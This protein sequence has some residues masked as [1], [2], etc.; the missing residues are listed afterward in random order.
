MAGFFDR[1]YVVIAVAALAAC[2]ASQAQSAEKPTIVVHA[3][4]GAVQ[5]NMVD[6]LQVFK[7]IPYAL[8]PVGPLRWRAPLPMPPWQ[9]VREATSFGP[10]CHQPASDSPSIYAW[11]AQSMSEDCLSLN[12]WAPVKA[13]HAPVFVWI[14]G[15]ALLT[16]SGADPMYDGTTLSRAGLIVV[17]INY[18]LGALGYLAHPALSAESSQKVSGNYGLL[19]QIAA[20]RWVKANI[21]AFGGDPDNV[22]V[23]GESAGGLS[24]MYLLASPEARGLFAKAISESAYMISTPELREPRFGSE[25]AETI[26]V[27]LANKLGTQDL[28]QLRG[29]DAARV[30]QTG[31]QAGGLPSAVVDGRILPRQLVDVFDRGE[32]AKVPLLVGFNSGE[33]RSLRMLAP[34]LPANADSYE[35]TIR[36]R[37]ADLS[38]DFLR[39]YPSTNLEGSLLATT[40]DA[41]YGWTAERL[42]IKQTALGV[43]AFLYYFDHGYPAADAAGLH[44]F[45]ASEIPYVFGITNE[46]PSLWPKVPAE[47][48]ELKLSA[49]MRGYWVSFAKYGMPAMAGQPTW[50][51]YSLNKAYMAFLDVPVPSAHPLP[52]AYELNEQIVC[53]RRF[54]GGVAWNWN[55][56]L[57]APPMPERVAGCR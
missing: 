15:G 16:G 56:G 34:P 21:A 40:R 39:L 52:G 51:P 6:G 33:I 32:Q 57:L 48:T 35:T 5:G 17:T 4:S 41:M 1:I 50:Q 31:A 3:K 37:Y 30:V 28:G 54:N 20:L 26:G 11:K 10:A 44:A 27:A 18:R 38:D 55:F 14:H 24:V 43:K 23:A 46:T 36:D 19:D 42:A 49:A 47:S 22:T 7:N 9:G 29:I 53:R 12:I 8:P 2:S 13:S 25:A 45:H